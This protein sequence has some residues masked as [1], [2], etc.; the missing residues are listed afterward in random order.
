MEKCLVQSNRRDTAIASPLAFKAGLEFSVASNAD[1]T[2][3]HIETAKLTY[4]VLSAFFDE[5]RA[6]LEEGSRKVVLDLEAVS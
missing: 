1:V 6:I 2:I 5:V 3:V 4:P